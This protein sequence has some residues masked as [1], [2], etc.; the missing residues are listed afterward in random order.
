M[1]WRCPACQTV[2][3]HDQHLPPEPRPGVVYRC[4]ICRLELVVDVDSNKLMVARLPD[5]NDRSNDR[6]RRTE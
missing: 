3:E 5:E 2:I 1:P 4:H 6:T